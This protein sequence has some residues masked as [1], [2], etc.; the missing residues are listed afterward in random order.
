MRLQVIDPGAKFACHSCGA[1]CDQPWRT[2]I[3]AVRAHALDRHDWSSYPQLAGRSFYHA[4][5]DGREGFYDLAKIE[6]TRC[7]FLDTDGLCIIHKELG[8]AAKPAMCQQ[9]PFLSART[10]VDERVSVNFG[11]PSVQQNIGEPIA[12]QAEAIARLVPTSGREAKPD[13]LVALA[14]NTMMTLRQADAL[15][16]QLIAAFD[17]TRPGDIWARFA[18]CLSL[19]VESAHS[20]ALTPADEQSASPV[21]EQG[22]APA[23]GQGVSP[24]NEQ[25]IPPV[26]G[27]R[28]AP[29][30]SRCKCDPV[31]IV[32]F[33]DRPARSLTLPLTRRADRPLV[34]VPFEDARKAPLGVRMLF[35]ATLHPD[36][37]PPDVTGRMK[38][39][40][41]L[42][43]IP[44]LMSL[45]QLNG[46]YASR[47]LGRNISIDAV[48]RHEVSP[49]LDEE[50]TRLLLRYFRS[51]IWQRML[52][53]T[54]LSIVA[55]LHQHIHD[56]NAILF[57]ARAEAM[58]GGRREL[59]GELIRRAL[60]RV[61]FHLANQPRLHEQVLKGWLRSQLDSAS[62]ACQS[63]RLMAVKRKDGLRMTN[64]ERSGPAPAPG[65]EPS[66][67]HASFVTITS[68]P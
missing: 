24:A 53:G 14:G 40:R 8:P 25:G 62:L 50:A 58:E 61:E 52:V 64:G 59:S 7:V 4:P 65:A 17:D 34:I 54:R 37:V 33:T 22:V 39:G 13:A 2:V 11:C 32:T 5:A 60:T 41:R 48:M 3:E 66:T 31:I 9:F 18:E 20:G 51:R 47:L 36:T 21:N 1:C 55:G 23:K 26:N 68:P 67:S 27:Q 28:V 42:A 6:G 38:I 29:A 43:M 57:F 63:L 30:N 49:E 56:L 46:G 35:A 19:A 10:W 15:I 44:R 12:G 45:A 16:N